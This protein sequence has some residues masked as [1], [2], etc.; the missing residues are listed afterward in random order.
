MPE[1]YDG[2]PKAIE[3][4]R[5]NV[6]R[7]GIVGSFVANDLRSSMIVVPLMEK[8]EDGRPLDYAAYSRALD[9]VRAKFETPDVRIRI[10][11]FAKLA[12]DLIHGLGVVMLFFGVAAAIAAF[13]I[14]LHTRCWRSTVLLVA[15]ALLG[16]LWLLGLMHLLGFVLDPYS[17]LVPFLIFSIGLSHGAQKMNGIMQDIGRGTHKYV[18]ARYT[19]RRLFLAGLTALLTNVVGFAV[20]M[21]ID[22]PVIRELALTTSIGVCILIFTK[23]LLVPVLLS[24][25]GVSPQ[26]ARRSLREGA[27][28]EHGQGVGK[29]WDLLVRFTDRRWAIACGARRGAARHARLRDEPEAADRRPRSRRARAARRLALQPRQRLHH[30]ELRLVERPVRDHGARRRPAA[31][32][33]PRRCSKA[34]ASHGRCGRTPACRT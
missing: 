12:G 17:I 9:E 23:L 19:F 29:A 14:V 33:R 22:I 13:I 24:Y 27:D 6:G 1:D 20:L 18:A 31:A 26:A 10:V 21:V 28:E 25:M 2:S 34:T 15:S 3:Q 8:T 16:V 5:L 30:R 32:T 11:G 7:A 4:L